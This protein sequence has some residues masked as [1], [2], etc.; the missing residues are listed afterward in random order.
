MFMD[1]GNLDT[2]NQILPEATKAMRQWKMAWMIGLHGT[3]VGSGLIFALTEKI[4]HNAHPPHAGAAASA[5]HGE[6]KH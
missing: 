3:F 4:G 2:E 5:A 1:V 6:A